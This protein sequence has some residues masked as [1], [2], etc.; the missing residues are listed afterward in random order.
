MKPS[1]RLLARA[2]PRPLALALAACL[3]VATASAA[4][5]QSEP[6]G[7]LFFTPEQR[8]ELDRQRRAP[9]PQPPTATQAAASFD[10]MVQRSSGKNTVWINGVP[11]DR[12]APPSGERGTGARSR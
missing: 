12:S 2:L 9:P 8:A 6:L 1:P 4:L 7:R 11:V 5:A 3:Q 10:G